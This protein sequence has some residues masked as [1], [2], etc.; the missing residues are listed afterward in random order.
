MVHLGT[1]GT[2]IIIY[3]CRVFVYVGTYRVTALLVMA[4]QKLV[5]LLSTQI[6]AYLQSTRATR[7]IPSKLK[8]SQHV[9]SFSSHMPI[10][11][12]VNVVN[13]NRIISSEP[14]N[15]LYGG[16]NAK[17]KANLINAQIIS[18]RGNN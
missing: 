4:P 18:I 8:I 5:Y 12:T 2:V 15:L 9:S 1:F 6:L 7:L 3:T 10:D 17:H 11:A 13:S 14:R 16:Y